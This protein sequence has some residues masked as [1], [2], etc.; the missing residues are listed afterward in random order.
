MLESSNG[1]NQ[2]WKTYTNLSIVPNSKLERQ[3]STGKIR[4]IDMPLHE[5][6]INLSGK[7]INREIEQDKI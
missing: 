7:N 3:K 1:C 5:H 2:L 6:Q 4:K